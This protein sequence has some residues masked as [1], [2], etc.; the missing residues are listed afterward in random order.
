MPSVTVK[1]PSTSCKASNHRLKV[2]NHNLDG[3]QLREERTDGELLLGE[4][5]YEEYL[6]HL[7]N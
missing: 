7:L 4:D 2:T 6:R 3:M 5:E 1:I